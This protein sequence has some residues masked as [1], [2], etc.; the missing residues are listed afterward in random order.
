M[1][2][3]PKIAD[4]IRKIKALRA[5]AADAASSE[6][7][8]AKAAEVADRLLREHNIDLSE[9][10]V[11]AEGVGTQ[12]WGNASA[13]RHPVKYA[14]VKIAK[15]TGCE[16]WLGSDGIVFLGSPTD[17]ELALYYTDLVN[18]ALESCLRAFKRTDDW[19]RVTGYWSPRK[20]A[21][22]FR[23]GVAGRLG[24]R[25][26][27]QSRAAEAA[28]P[29]GTGLVVVKNQLIRQW[30]EDE[31]LRFKN[32]G[33]KTRR[34]EAYAHGQRAAEGVGIGRGVGTQRSTQSAIGGW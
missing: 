11:R 27:E 26:L 5:R 29:T 21:A 19:V 14:V 6:N 1:T 25:I 4:I 24:A 10:D 8:A 15:A 31:G 17:V 3:S 23:V 34:G 7:E 32:A 30:L 16:V 12:V 18:N 9:L 28:Q 33:R 2:Q 13:R 20:A 22:D